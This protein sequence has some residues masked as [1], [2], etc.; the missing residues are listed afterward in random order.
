MTQQAIYRRSPLLLAAL[1]I[2]VLIAAGVVLRRL[3]AFAE[4]NL[5]G[6]PQLV[7]LDQAFSGHRGLT[8]AHILPALVFAVLAPVALLRRN[9][10][11][12]KPLLLP[13]GTVVGITAYVMSTFA[14][15]GRW[16]QAAVLFFN[17]LFLYWLWRSHIPGRLGDTEDARRSLLR[18]TVVLLGIATTRPV[19]SIF[20]ATSRL[21]GLQPDQFFGPAFWIG[22]S[23]NTLAV[24]WYLRRHPRSTASIGVQST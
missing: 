16:E 7:A 15:G 20:F 14:V 10:L 21:T 18:S 12:I 11:W 23:I 8:L 5:A 4:P 1:W 13:L 9:A 17:S 19:M 2:S 6:P 3:Y 24:E 22:F